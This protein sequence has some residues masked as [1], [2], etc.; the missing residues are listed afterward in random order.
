[1]ERCKS[2]FYFSI[3]VVSCTKKLWLIFE[4]QNYKLKTYKKHLFI[5]FFRDA[6]M[7]DNYSLYEK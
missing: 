5:Y 2:L 3:I 1:M 4:M 6:T 7:I